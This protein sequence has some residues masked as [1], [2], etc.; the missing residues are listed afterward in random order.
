MTLIELIFFLLII[1][2]GLFSS[3]HFGND[4]GVV[5]Y[6]LGFFVGLAGS[7][8]GLF[9]FTEIGS[10]IENAIWGGIPRFPK[11]RNKK[12]EKDDYQFV[13]ISSG[14]YVSQCGCGDY[15]QKE[16]RMIW[17]KS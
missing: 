15:Y 5:G 2:I 14:E 12:C 4:Y 11:C 10:F 16:G 6:L 13:K 7:I 1:S 3:P 17:V 9:L 8:L